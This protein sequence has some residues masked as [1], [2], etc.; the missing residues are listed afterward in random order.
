MEVSITPENCIYTSCFCEE[1]VWKLCESFKEKLRLCEFYVVFISNPSKQIPLWCQRSSE[2]NSQPVVWDYH[3]ILLHKRTT[4]AYVY[5]LDTTLDFPCNLKEYAE[6]A[7]QNESQFITTF[8]RFFR[9]IPAPYFLKT[10]ASDRSH[11]KNNDGE[12]MKPPP[13]Y[14][15]IKTQDSSMNLFEFIDMKTDNGHGTIMDM[16]KLLEHFYCEVNWLQ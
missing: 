5:D 10:F 11:M 1:N 3:V 12:W 8:H 6:K 4:D 2:I 7:L 15:L 16:K 13:N 9:V 14:P